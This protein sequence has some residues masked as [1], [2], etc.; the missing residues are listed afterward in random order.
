MRSAIQVT[1]LAISTSLTVTLL[2]ST[3]MRTA[4]P[5]RVEHIISAGPAWRLMIF[6]CILASKP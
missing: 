4:A 3:P 1:T 2:T 6:L 5:I